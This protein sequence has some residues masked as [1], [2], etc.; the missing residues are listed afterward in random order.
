[1]THTPTGEK[2]QTLLELVVV[3]LV[4]GIIIT[5]IIAIVSASVRN[6]RFS[7]DQAQASRFAQEALE[8]VRQRRDSDWTTFASKNS[9]TYCMISLSWDHA[10]PCT[11]T[12]YI[13]GTNFLR[14]V[15][16]SSVNANTISTD[17]TVSWNDSNGVHQSRLSTHLSN[18]K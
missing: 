4:V 6:A 3:L 7:K 8:W 11:S 9:A 18:W 17:V 10:T 15:T 1:M 16:L 2:G 12:D 5:G 13:V 14:N